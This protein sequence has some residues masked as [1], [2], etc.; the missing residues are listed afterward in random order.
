M[1][2]ATAT[3]IEVNSDDLK[4]QCEQQTS[5]SHCNYKDS[6]SVGILNKHLPERT[7]ILT[8][9]RNKYVNNIKIDDQIEI[10]ISA[11]SVLH[12]A[13]L[14][15]LVPLFF[16]FIIAIGLDFFAIDE[17]III[18]SSVLGLITGMLFVS[19]IT[20]KTNITDDFKIEIL[21]VLPRS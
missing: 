3:V 6:C 18:L 7:Q 13:I 11:N 10:G 2:K 14:I 21:R 4:V 20:K 1:L 9:P 16:M 8:I 5:C 19:K 12:S 17:K 15:Y